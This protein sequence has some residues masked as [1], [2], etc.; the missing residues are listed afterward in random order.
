MIRIG[1]RLGA[2]ATTIAFR[3]Q[4]CVI[5]QIDQQ[6]MPP[7]P[8]PLRD[9]ALEPAALAVCPPGAEPQIRRGIR[10][11][12]DHDVI[13]ERTVGP[14]RQWHHGGERRTQGCADHAVTGGQQ[15]SAGDPD[16]GPEC[17]DQGGGRTGHMHRSAVVQR[18]STGLVAVGKVHRS[19]GQ[20]DGT[21]A[22]DRVHGEVVAGKHETPARIDVH[23]HGRQIDI[24]GERH[25]ACHRHL[26]DQRWH[27]QAYTGT[28]PNRAVAGDRPCQGHRSGDR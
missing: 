21:R 16:V 15:G 1:R 17:A 18:D 26:V 25:R 13:G 5:T 28:E 8:K 23:M 19:A 10:R 6:V 12:I 14:I 20:G 27:G 24:G 3:N 2:P 11:H 22:A 9:H 4:G 7:G